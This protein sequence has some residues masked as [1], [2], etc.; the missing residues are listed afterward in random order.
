M[1]GEPEA[2]QDDTLRSAGISPRE[3]LERIEHVLERIE[4]KMDTRF[5]VLEQRVWSLELASSIPIANKE[6]ID[7]VKVILESIKARM[8]M[9]VGGLAVLMV[10][11]NVGI[12]NRWF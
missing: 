1:D 4:N 11:I 12:A 10:V 2:Y 6:E 8:W 3:R 7:D 9:A 5:G